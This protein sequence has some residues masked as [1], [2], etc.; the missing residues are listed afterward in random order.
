MTMNHQKK[1]KEQ[2]T[3]DKEPLLKQLDH[4][5]TVKWQEKTFKAIEARIRGEGAT[6]DCVVS[7]RLESA[8]S[9]PSIIKTI[10]LILF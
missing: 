4:E 3:Y 2:Q 5:T 8:T 6:I 10:G 9:I 7:W 1:K